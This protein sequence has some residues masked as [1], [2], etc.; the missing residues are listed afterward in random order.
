MLSVKIEGYE[1]PMKLDSGAPLGIINK[2]CLQLIKPGFSLIKSDRKF[3][4]YTEDPVKC[5]GK[6]QVNVT[7]GKTSK[8][9]EVYVVEDDLDALFGRIWIVAFIH[10]IDFVELFTPSDHVRTITTSAPQLSPEQQQLKSLLSRYED[11]FSTVPGKLVGPPAKVHF[12]PGAT[13]VFA[14]AR[15]I[16]FAL[17]PAYAKEFDE[18]IAAG[19]YEKVEFLE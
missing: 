9:L 4:S 5:I 16:L 7:L 14:R 3:V 12:K 2:R 6:T 13:P 18:K 1:V 19:F 10:E 11:F 17:R 15:E 8:N